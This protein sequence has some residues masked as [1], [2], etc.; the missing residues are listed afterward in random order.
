MPEKG[1]AI[2]VAS[3][4]ARNGKTLLARLIAD[5]LL[6]MG[7][8]PRLF[9]TDAA[10]K[11]LSLYFPARSTVIDLERVPDQMKLFDTL[12][13]SPSETRVV[14]L[15]H[16]SFQKFFHMMR[17]IDFVAEAGLCDVETVLFYIPDR[18]PE[19]WEQGRILRDQFHDCAFVLV[20]NAAVGELGRETLRGNAYRALR[21]HSLKLCMPQLDPFFAGAIAD[22]ALSLSEF[23]R[24]QPGRPRPQQ[25]PFAYLSLE[26]RAA[27]T[28]WLK[29]TFREIGQILESLEN[30]AAALPGP[31]AG[32]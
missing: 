28:T 32:F 9:D 26:G 27:I 4:R 22:T 17:E 23:L 1:L 3:P 25:M 13:S 11:K 29:Q 15:T 5:H 12:A 2:I 16:R 20:E 24:P 30:R 14:D 21:T 10:E 31:T 19:S 6:L 7:E 18:D 8:A